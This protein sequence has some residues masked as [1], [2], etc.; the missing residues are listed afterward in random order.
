MFQ[1]QASSKAAKSYGLEFLNSQTGHS[2][3]H[4]FFPQYSETH[5]SLQYGMT[6]N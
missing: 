6:H 2:H 1:T 5:N 3:T 4:T